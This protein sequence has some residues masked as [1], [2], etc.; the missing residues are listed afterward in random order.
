MKPR[1]AKRRQKTEDKSRLEPEDSFLDSVLCLRSSVFEFPVFQICLRRK[2]VFGFRSS[3]AVAGLHRIT[4]GAPEGICQ[5]APCSDWFVLRS[6][7]LFLLGATGQIFWNI[8]SRGFQ[9]ILGG[10][11]QISSSVFGLRSSVFGLRATSRAFT[12]SLRARSGDL[13][14]SSSE[15]WSRYF[16]SEVADFFRLPEGLF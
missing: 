12:G 9:Q 13:P 15:P 4:C 3:R 16:G 5:V 11:Q 14:S 10:F 6:S 1:G 8:C 7:S 2:T